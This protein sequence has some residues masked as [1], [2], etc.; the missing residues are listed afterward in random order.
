MEDLMSISPEK[1]LDFNLAGERRKNITLKMIRVI[2]RSAEVLA[3]QQHG[4]S[5]A[6]NVRMQAE[7]A[8]PLEEQEMSREIFIN[9][10]QNCEEL[11]RFCLRAG[12]LL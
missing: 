1:P 5:T 2:F 6:G 3:Q 7:N 10:C 8:P 4:A 9:I 12:Y 11:S